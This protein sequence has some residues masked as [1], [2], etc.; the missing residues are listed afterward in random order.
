L[1]SRTLDII[2]LDDQKTVEKQQLVVDQ[3]APEDLRREDRELVGT[4]PAD[5]L[6]RTILRRH[7][8]IFDQ[9]NPLS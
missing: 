7:V 8:G 9:A 3:V 2:G 5:K 1:V 4:D 6:Q